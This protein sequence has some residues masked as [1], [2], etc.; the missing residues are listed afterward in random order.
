MHDASRYQDKYQN[1]SYLARDQYRDSRHLDAR[2]ELHRRF[3]TNRSGWFDWVCEQMQLEAGLRVLECGCGPGWL[4]RATLERIP[5]DCQIT[6][7]DLSDG[8]VAEARAALSNTAVAFHF[9]TADITNLPFDDNSFDLVIANHMLYHVPDLPRALAEVRRVLTEP[10][11]FVCATNGEAHM[12]ELRSLRGR[13]L[14]S[15]DWTG[16]SLPFTLENGAAQLAGTFAT[17]TRLDYADS[18]AV[19]E[20]EPLIAYML[21]ESGAETAVDPATLASLRQELQTTID[22]RGAFIITKASGLFSAH[23]QQ[24]ERAA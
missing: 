21:S 1:K 10:G 7:T 2:A 18:L 12:R 5:P 4:W 6:L 9:Q 14:P 24:K 17:V 16:M 23:G 22:T 13:L 11:R 15:L 8:M 20:V 3:S 19:T